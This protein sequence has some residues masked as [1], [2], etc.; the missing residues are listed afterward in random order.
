MI[1]SWAHKARITA[2]VTAKEK[3]LKAKRRLFILALEDGAEFSGR[4]PVI[5]LGLDMKSPF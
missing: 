3:G 4:D 1:R 2:S 5:G